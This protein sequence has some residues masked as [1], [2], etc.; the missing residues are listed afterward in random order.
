MANRSVHGASA[1]RCQVTSDQR[2]W[3]RS[4]RWSRAPRS[5]ANAAYHMSVRE[6]VRRPG[7]DRPAFYGRTSADRSSGVGCPDGLGTFG[8]GAETY[9]P[10][11]ID[12]VKN[13]TPCRDCSRKNVT[14]V[15][16]WPRVVWGCLPI[17]TRNYSLLAPHRDAMDTMSAVNY[18]V[19]ILAFFITGFLGRCCGA[20]G[21]AQREEA[22]LPRAL[23]QLHRDDR[24]RGAACLVCDPVQ[25]IAQLPAAHRNR[26]RNTLI[27]Q[28][29]VPAPADPRSTL[30]RATSCNSCS[31]SCL[32]KV[33]PPEG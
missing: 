20:E 12:D 24:F 30:P 27:S 3:P 9:R 21:V 32:S 29:G 8:A 6:I 28:G 17:R 10:R 13:R 1:L 14:C 25:Q 11:E 5:R 33:V 19:V 16:K 4:F 31:N 2:K 15:T 7:K 26:Q 22:C 18:P 23:R